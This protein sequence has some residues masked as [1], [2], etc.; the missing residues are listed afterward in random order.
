MKSW[1]Q[2][3]LSATPQA[4]LQIDDEAFFAQ[5]RA[6]EYSRLDAQHHV[7]LDYTGGGLYAKSQIEKHHALL[8]DQVFGN[9]HST[10][11]TSQLSTNLVEAAR[12]KVLDFFN[13]SEHYHCVFTANASAS[14]KIVGEGYPFEQNGAFV[15]LADNHNSVNGIREFCKKHGGEFEYCPINYEDLTIQHDVLNAIFKRFEGKEHKLFA[16]PAQSNVTGVKHDLGWV[17]RAQELGWDVLL[18]AAAFVTT[19]RLDLTE[20]EPEFVSASFYKIFGYPTGLGCLLIHKRA[21]Q[22]LRKPWFAGGTVTYASVNGGHHYLHNNYERF[23]DGTVNYLDIP[24]IKIGLDYI[25]TIG[26][27]R[28]HRRIKALASTVV[29]E[30]TAITHTNGM[31]VVRIFGSLDMEKHGGSLV[32]TFFDSEGKKYAYED[33]EQMTNQLKISIRSGCFCNP[34]VDEINSCI[35]NDDFG[36]YFSSRKMDDYDQML[37]QLKRMRGGTRL[38]VGVPTIASDIEQ[39]IGFVKS[40]VDKKY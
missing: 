19:S 6:Q 7:Y 34:G 33:I 18:D 1:F 8:Q 12:Q 9:P 30:L 21:F 2:S 32:M 26:M 36:N 11:P 3:L 39:F 31:P 29:R 27:E 22:K 4:P 35:T 23:E 14:L 40:L 37:R 10:N 17:A 13:A 28:I 15:L 16:F 38:S 24:A 5:L 25:E 20:V